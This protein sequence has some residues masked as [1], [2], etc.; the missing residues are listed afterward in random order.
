MSKE[1]LRYAI[2]KIIEEST[3]VDLDNSLSE[4]QR[5]ALYGI[6]KFLD[7]EGYITNVLYS[8]DTVEMD[9]CIEITEKG[10][11]YLQDNSKMSKLYKGI[12]E[13]RSWI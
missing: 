11:K 9:E 8:D 12:K 13:L 6:I 7:R 10:E 1:G 5:E 2:L 3:I 4:V